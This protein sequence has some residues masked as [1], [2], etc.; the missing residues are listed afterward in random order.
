MGKKQTLE[1]LTTALSKL[2]Q[3]EAALKNNKGYTQ[4]ALDLEMLI[5]FIKEQVGS[6]NSSLTAS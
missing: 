5:E 2:T 6:E 4:E 1:K 3:L